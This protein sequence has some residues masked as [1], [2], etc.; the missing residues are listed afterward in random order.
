VHCLPD[1]ICTQHFEASLEAQESP[2]RSVQ[3][4]KPIDLASAGGEPETTADP[5]QDSRPVRAYLDYRRVRPNDHV[6]GFAL[7]YTAPV[8]PGNRG[9]DVGPDDGTGTG[10]R[11]TL[12]RLRCARVVESDGLAAN[13]AQEIALSRHGVIVDEFE[14]ES[15]SDGRPADNPPY[16]WEAEYS[17]QSVSMV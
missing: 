14:L 12:Q 1:L 6:A 15:A 4:T 11:C 10:A 9:G 2:R 13:D 17:C 3:Q 8:P 5:A 7:R 16:Y